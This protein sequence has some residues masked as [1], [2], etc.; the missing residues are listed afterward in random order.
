MDLLSTH[1]IF[2]TPSSLAVS[3]DFY[4]RFWGNRTR[5]F[6]A[7]AKYLTIWPAGPVC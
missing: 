5:R 2:M 3:T 4:M 7:V 1:E 6:L